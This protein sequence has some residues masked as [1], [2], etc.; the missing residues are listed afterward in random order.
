M[1]LRDRLAR[2]LYRPLDGAIEQVDKA[3]EFRKENPYS[4]TADY[5]RFAYEQADHVLSMVREASEGA[6]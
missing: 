3:W 1:E 4:D 5:V 6:R 2:Y